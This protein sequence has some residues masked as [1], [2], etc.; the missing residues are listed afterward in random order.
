MLMT[1]RYSME[2]SPA[3]KLDFG[4]PH[5]GEMFKRSGY[6]TAIFGKYQ[7]L[8]SDLINT[9]QTEE[10]RQAQ[11][12]AQKAFNQAAYGSGGATGYEPWME[13]PMFYTPGVYELTTGPQ[14]HSYD[15]SFTSRPGYQPSH[16]F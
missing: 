16:Y 3:R 2:D 1:G 4:T 8:K 11:K 12:K 5:M 14:N 7:P 15:Y 13:R 10:E 9:S 6:H